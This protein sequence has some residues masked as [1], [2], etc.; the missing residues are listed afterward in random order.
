M[1]DGMSQEGAGCMERPHNGATGRLPDIVNGN[2]DEDK[3]GL[4]NA[5]VILYDEAMQ[6]QATPQFAFTCSCIGRA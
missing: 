4:D 6:H 1:S 5:P 2:G 3:K